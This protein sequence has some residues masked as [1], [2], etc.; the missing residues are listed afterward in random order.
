MKRDLIYAEGW[1][2]SMRFVFNKTKV[3]S[4]IKKA[5]KRPSFGYGHGFITD[6]SVVLVEEQHMH[7]TILEACGTL[8]PECK[9]TAKSFQGLMNLPDTPIEVIDSQLEFIPDP[10]SRLRIFYDPKTGKELTINGIYFDLLDNPE[11]HKFYTNDP[12]D[13]M[14]IMC[15]DEVVGVVAPVRLQNELCHVNF[16]VYEGGVRECCNVQKRADKA[17]A[18]AKEV[19]GDE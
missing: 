17:L 5:H 13:K 16:E 11:A 14:W 18:K 8:T 9:Y 15:G 7:P 3:K 12:M 19:L 2:E 1:N 6:G 10:K 4:W